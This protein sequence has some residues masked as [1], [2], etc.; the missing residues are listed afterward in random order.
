MGAGMIQA[1]AKCRVRVCELEYMCQYLQAVISAM[2]HI[3]PPLIP[4]PVWNSAFHL[5]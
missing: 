2:V 3:V 4:P 1:R 5:K